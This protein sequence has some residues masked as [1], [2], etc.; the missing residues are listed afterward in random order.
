VI[1]ALLG[2]P[3]DVLLAL[4]LAGAYALFGLGIVVIYRASRVLN[5]A[6]GAIA[7]MPA[8]VVYALA[9]SLGVWPAV[10]V[11]LLAGAA[12][13]AGVERLVI[14]RLRSVSPTA[15][16]VG[17][18][19]VFSLLVALMARIWGTSLLPGVGVVP[20]HAFPVGHALMFTGDLALLA[21]AGAG[22]VAFFVLFRYS[23]LGM[24]MSLAADNRRAASLM[25]INPE[26]TTLAAWA[27]GGAFAALGGILLAG[28]SGLHPYLLPLQMLPAFV[29]ALIGGLDS[30]VG[31]VIGSLV[32]GAAVGIVP[33]LGSVGQ[34]PGTPELAVTLL[35]FLVMALRGVKLQAGDVRSGLA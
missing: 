2:A 16:T 11:G 13:G 33:A 31:A 27:L 22:C 25:G 3:V 14:R 9:P 20:R 19:A 6:H 7:T 30:A 1:Q 10:L 32:V 12:L 4:P 29:A 18:V 35:A 28:D 21:A 23:S 17:T 24:A 5:L 8:Y 15:Q 26:R 34:Q